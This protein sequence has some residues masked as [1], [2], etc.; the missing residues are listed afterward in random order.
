MLS[1]PR[2]SSGPRPTLPEISAG[3]ASGVGDLTV[4]GLNDQYFVSERKED[5]RPRAPDLEPGA[6]TSAQRLA[7]S[8][9]NTA[10][11]N[12]GVFERAVNNATPQI[13]EI[14]D[15]RGRAG[16]NY[17][18]R[19]AKQALDLLA[20]IADKYKDKDFGKEAKAALE[21]IAKDENS[22]VRAHAQ[23]LLK[24]K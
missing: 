5:T 6:T 12:G 23:S 11:R 16:A 10:V 21:R 18:E 13:I 1:N 24:P 22:Q 2:S 8:T 9:I 17:D 20:A 19:T 15:A 14:A 3:S 4:P 7:M